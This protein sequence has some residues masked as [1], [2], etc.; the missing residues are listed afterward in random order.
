MIPFDPARLDA[1]TKI[2]SAMRDAALPLLR[3]HPPD[4]AFEAVVAML[5]FVG[6]K[7]GMSYEDIVAH[8]QLSAIGLASE[9]S[10]D[11]A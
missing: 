8:V 9:D 5:F 6:E 1:M 7:A 10:E 2:A 4:V 3:Q 11:E